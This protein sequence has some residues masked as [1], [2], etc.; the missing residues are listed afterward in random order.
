MI[1]RSSLMV[2]ASDRRHETVLVR[3]GQFRVGAI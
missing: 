1:V 2:E 3:S